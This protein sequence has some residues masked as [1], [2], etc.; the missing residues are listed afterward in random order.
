MRS[1]YSYTGTSYRTY[2]RTKRDADPV[3]AGMAAYALKEYDCVDRVEG[4][5]TFLP[6]WLS[7]EL[8]SEGKIT[9]EAV[10]EALAKAKKAYRPDRK[11]RD[12]YPYENAGLKFD[13]F[14]PYDDRFNDYDCRTY[15]AVLDHKVTEEEE[16][17]LREHLTVE[18]CDPYCD[19][20]DCTGAPFTR[21]LEFYKCEDRTI[22]LHK[23]VFDV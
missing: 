12:P 5:Y 22:V 7:R 1:V 23:I 10:Q 8:Y 2:A 20:R 14:R 4:A 6:Y 21:W 3:K 9:A 18:F 13:F 11:V 19:G 17:E 16:K 15:K